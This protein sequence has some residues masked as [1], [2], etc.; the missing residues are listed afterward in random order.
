M[1][2][3]LLVVSFIVGCA[4]YEEDPILEQPMSIEERLGIVEV[5]LTDSKLMVPSV[6]V[7]KNGTIVRWYNQDDLGFYHNL[8]IHPRKIILPTPEDIIAQSGNIL[9]GNYWEYTFMESGEYV[10]KDIYSGTM[11]G[12]ITAEVTTDIVG[13]ALYDG[14]V[15]GR[16]SVV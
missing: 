1:I 16:I 15:I 6:L 3:I 14:E 13:D 12:E 10:I 8:I 5:N 4:S 7:I 2:L 9:P 11:R